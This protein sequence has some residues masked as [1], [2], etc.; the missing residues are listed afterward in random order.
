M[1]VRLLPKP[2]APECLLQNAF[3]RGIDAGPAASSCQAATK[4]LPECRHSSR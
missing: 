3:D 4:P 2:L 1:A